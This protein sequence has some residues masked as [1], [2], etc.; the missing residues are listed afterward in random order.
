MI[1]EAGHIPAWRQLA[2]RAEVVAVSSRRLERARNTAARHGIAKA[3]DDWPKMLEEERPDLVSICTPNAHHRPVAEA[4]LAAGAHVFC[5]KPIATSAADAAAM[6]QAA[7]RAGRHLMVA[8]TARFSSEARAAASLVASGVLGELYYAET[9]LLRR[10]GIPTW[11]RFHMKEHSG[12]GPL[13]DLGVHALDLIYW[14]MGNPRT[15]A[16]SGLTFRRLGDRATA[17][18]TTGGAS[19]APIGV[20]DPRA[21]APE[22]FDV[23]E[24]AVGLIR[25]EGGAGI[26]VRTSWAANVPTGGILDTLLLGTEA[27]MS[28]RPLELYGHTAGYPAN[29]TPEVPPDPD[30]PFYGH[31]LAAAHLL[32]VI[33]GRE[34]P[35]V[36]REEVMGV[37]SALEALYRS[38]ELGREVAV[39]GDGRV[40]GGRPWT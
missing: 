1:A 36:R 31:R 9:T 19:G 6:Y 11:G 37:M 40:E 26:V 22:E 18:A 28:L 7:A 17:L 4:A 3:Y 20:N 16:A 38:A 14:L 24:M 5:E 34:E 21:Y 12:G 30:V 32:E 13:Y 35:L 23:E 39:G 2:G 10:R 15:V 27:G 29:I 25:L 8:Q 33:V